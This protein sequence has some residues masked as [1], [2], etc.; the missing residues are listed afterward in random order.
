ML[1]VHCVICLSFV[2]VRYLLEQTLATI[3]AGGGVV[4]AGPTTVSDGKGT[5]ITLRVGPD[6]NRVSLDVSWA[7]AS[8]AAGAAK[9][10]NFVLR[11]E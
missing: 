10:G 11:G 7:A 5:Q 4:P 3:V 8:G 9:Q 6:S 2:V 1:C